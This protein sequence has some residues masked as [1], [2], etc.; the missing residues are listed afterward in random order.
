MTTVTKKPKSGPKVP[1]LAELRDALLQNRQEMDRL[2][3]QVEAALHGNQAGRTQEETFPRSFSPAS[4][5][6]TSPLDNVQGVLEITRDLRLA[7][8]NLSADRVAKLFGIPLSRLAEWLGRT[9]QAVSKTP[10]A[11]S[12]QDALGYF[13]RIARL[14]LATRGDAEFRQWL[15]TSHPA[16]AGK[17]PLE[18]LAR[19]KWQSLA[20]L[21][22]DILSGTPS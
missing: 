6:R 22:D 8:G 14:R 18:L 17:N 2:L 5:A 21:V 1:S 12:L 4:P 13:E 19:G 10:D 9:K 16:V 15:R 3:V 20:D 7:N 11:D